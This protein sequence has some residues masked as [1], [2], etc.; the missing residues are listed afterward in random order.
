MAIGCNANCTKQLELPWPRIGRKAGGGSKR[1]CRGLLHFTR[2]DSIVMFV[3]L[4]GHM[5]RQ[6]TS[7]GMI[8]PLFVGGFHL[9]LK[10]QL[11]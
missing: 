2:A 1:N 8:S 7:R 6:C 5:L 10:H 9:L 3:L 11:F 4:H